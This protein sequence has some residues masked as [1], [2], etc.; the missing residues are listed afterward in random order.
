MS[1][2]GKTKEVNW[3]YCNYCEYKELDQSEDP[4]HE[5]LENPYNEYS[6]RPVN[7]K[8]SKEIIL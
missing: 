1:N 2:G 8:G 6:H 5:C 4:C 3:E 7:Y